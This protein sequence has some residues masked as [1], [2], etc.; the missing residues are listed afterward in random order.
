LEKTKTEK[1]TKV[2]LDGSVLALGN[3]ERAARSILASC[4]KSFV[5]GIESACRGMKSLCENRMDR[6]TKVLPETRDACSSSPQ[7]AVA[8][9]VVCIVGVCALAAL[10]VRLLKSSEAVE[11]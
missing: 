2:P 3:T 7:G 5:R 9:I 4:E 8:P 11:V 10:G 6:L 1:S